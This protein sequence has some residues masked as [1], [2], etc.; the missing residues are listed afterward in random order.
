MPRPKDAPHFAGFSTPYFTQMPNVVLDD[1]LADLSGAEFK[2]LAYI[3]RRTYGW[4]K[5]SDNI[6]LKQLAEGIKGVDRG[7]GLSKS[8]VA[9][10]LKSLEE[11]GIIERIQNHDDV[12]GDLP[13]TYRVRLSDTGGDEN[14][15]PPAS[16]IG[17][18]GVRESDTQKI[19]PQN[20]NQKIVGITRE[21]LERYE[22]TA[23][24]GRR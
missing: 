10:A 16:E 3:L 17:H 15:T 21:K 4:H 13:T 22:Q 24:R 20:T 18:G 6:G 7:T 2:V 14:R 5:D 11:W 12:R 1:L 19:D 9:V 8:T 23:A